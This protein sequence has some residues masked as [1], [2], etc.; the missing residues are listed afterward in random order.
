M[1]SERS[2]VIEEVVGAGE[3]DIPLP[4]ETAMGSSSGDTLGDGSGNGIDAQG[5][6]SEAADLGESS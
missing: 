1:E 4:E 2:L 6:G 3:I 5:E